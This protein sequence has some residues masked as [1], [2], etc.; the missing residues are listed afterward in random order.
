MF[1][2]MH[3]MKLCL[4]ASP[5]QAEARNALLRNFT[6]SAGMLQALLMM[7]LVDPH[8]ALVCIGN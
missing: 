4:E 3:Q 7:K 5:D 2:L 1:N 8:E 6:L